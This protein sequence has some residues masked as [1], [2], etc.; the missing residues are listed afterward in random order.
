MATKTAKKT[1]KRFD[2]NKTVDTVKSTAK[3]ANEFILETSEDV[4]EATI[5]TAGQWQTVGEKAVKGGLKLVSTQQDIVFD[6]LEAI[7]VQLTEGRSRVKD[8]FSRN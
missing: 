6:T 5:N 7:K 8:L 2:F 1:E 4:I 3:D